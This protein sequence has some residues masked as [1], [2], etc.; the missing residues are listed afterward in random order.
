MTSDRP[1]TDRRS[2]LKF[3]GVAA[4]TALAG[5]S[6][7]DGDGDGGGGANHEVPHP[8]DGTVPDAERNAEALNGQTGE[9]NQGKD[10]VGYAH[11]PS[12]DQNCGNCGLFVPDQDGDGFGA[13]ILVQGK[14]HACDYCDLWSSYDGDDT[15]ACEA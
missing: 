13:C 3:A 6:G 7:G 10:A 8:D 4:L 5:C 14:I 1:Y 11:E 2:Y 9:P 12:G 15:V